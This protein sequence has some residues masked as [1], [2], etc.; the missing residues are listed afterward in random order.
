MNGKWVGLIVLLCAAIAGGSLFYLQVWGFYDRVTPVAGQE[1]QIARLTAQSSLDDAASESLA[2]TDFQAI[3]ADSSPIRY[4]ACFATQVSAQDLAARY[5]PYG[6]AVPR[7][8]PFWFDCFDARSIGEGVANGDISLYLG[9][10]NI[11]FGVDR[12]VAIDTLGRGWVWHEL[13]NCGKK[14]YDGTVTG[15]ICPPR[16]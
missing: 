11:S 10:K 6:A 14:E 9:Q 12:I 7:N 3:D 15:E 13:N 8:A 5:Q 16:E 1:V 2:V 4:R